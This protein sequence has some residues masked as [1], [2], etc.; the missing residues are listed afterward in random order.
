MIVLERDELR[1]VIACVLVERNC[2]ALPLVHVESPIEFV[3]QAEALLAKKD[4]PPAA[5]HVFDRFGGRTFFARAAWIP[6]ENGYAW[7]FGYDDAIVLNKLI[8]I[9]RLRASCAAPCSQR[10][11]R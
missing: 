6:R 1:V 9:L 2:E 8:N 10:C 11:G 4:M 3:S 7:R 5:E